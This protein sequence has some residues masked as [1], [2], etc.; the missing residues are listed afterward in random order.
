MP[1]TF[2]NMGAIK[3]RQVMELKLPRLMEGRLGFELF[4]IT[5]V[6]EDF[7]FYERKTLRLGLQGARGVGGPTAPIIHRGVDVFRVTPGYYGD[8][9]TIDESDLVRLREAGDWSAFSSYASQT[10]EAT[11]YLTQRYLDRAESSIWAMLQTG[12]FSATN[13]QGVVMHNDLFTITGYTPGILWNVPAT[14][15]PLANLRSY[16]EQSEKGVSAKFKSGRLVGTRGTINNIL[17]NTNAADIG[18]KRVGGGN[19]VNAMEQ[20]NQILLDNDLPQL[21]IY[22][23][24]YYPEPTG[25]AFSK[26]LTDGK[27]VA[28]GARTDGESIGEYRLTRAAQNTNSGPGEWYTVKDKRDENPPEVIISGG[29]NGGPVPFYPEALFVVNAY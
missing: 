25:T 24:G 23:E 4:P 5:Q 18:G 1:S 9:Y 29:H 11:D 19:S 10:G 14:A 26:F 28:F 13:K 16:V 17:N 21:E 12:A 15:I 27:L 22:D 2:E 7:L 6:N 8:H 3:V 20:V